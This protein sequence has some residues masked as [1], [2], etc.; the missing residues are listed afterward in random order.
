VRPTPRQRDALAVVAEGRFYPDIVR[1]EDG[2]H[3][4]WRTFGSDDNPWVDEFVRRAAAT[5]LAADAEHQRHETLHDAWMAALRSGTGLVVWDDGE[6]AEFAADLAE[7]HGGGEEDTAVRRAIV[8][9]FAPSKEGFS[10][11]CATPKGRKALKALGQAAYVFGPLRGLK[12]DGQML[13][14]R[15]E[16]AD[17]EAFLRQGAYELA[18]AGYTVED[19][20]VSAKVCASAEICDGEQADA[21]DGEQTC[22]AKLRIHVAGEEVSAA[23]IRFLLDQGSSLVWFRNRWIEVDRGILKEALRALEKSGGAKLSRMEAVAFASGIGR[24]GRLEMEEVALHGW[25][26]GLVNR[27]KDAGRGSL[28][29]E[30][31]P[32]DGLVS[33]ELRDYQKRGVAWMRFLV[34]NGFGALLADE[35]GLGKTIQTIAWV[36]ASR[37]D[38]PV[39]VVAPLTLLAN[40]RHE[41]ERFSPGLK[42]YVHQGDRRDL[43]IG[44]RR[45]ARAADVVVTSY[46]LLVRDHRDIAE[47]AW[48][49]LVLDEAQAIKNPDTQA[50]RSV[51]ALGARR[52]I[53]LTG[54]PVENSAADIWSIEEFLNPGL[55]GD[56][57]TFAERFLKP[58]AVEP[59]GAAAK[60]LR[61]ALEPF[62]LRRLKSDGGVAD[63]LGPKREIRE[64]CTLSDRERADYETALADYRASERRQG[65]VFALIT[66]LKLACDG[67]DAD[68]GKFMRLVEILEGVFAAGESALVFSQYAKVGAALKSAL[69]ARFSRRVRF[70]HG[71]L[72][73]KE[74]ERE[75]A[76][77]SRSREPSVMVLSLR[78]GGFGLNLVKAT[79]VI[80]YDRWWNPAVENQAT[81]RAHRIGQTGTVFVHLMMAEGTLE[82][83]V[84]GL[85]R[86]KS[87]LAGALVADGESFLARMS[88]SELEGVVRL[89]A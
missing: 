88:A 31:V 4:R 63:E 34:E 39:L 65:D 41:L 52:R 36:V 68:S 23:E 78:A 42:V 21:R 8:F 89:E 6:C 32:A 60:R 5:P 57:K 24:I 15:L 86:S 75:V 20:D 46:S 35:M 1:E 2:W 26:R 48:S 28:L 59:D 53:A 54:T 81:D 7:W 43:G 40:W 62:V 25:L 70:L 19:A 12:A 29:S 33:G 49:A 51:R 18:E 82:E 38:G 27:L 79:H 87:A 16:R 30:L 66:R 10:I 73:A 45:R 47:I 85:L 3:A 67:T 76:A 84:D 22:R 14:V 13:R 72:S 55:L 50:A 69:E 77:F 17:A 83:R 61:H 71:G 44:F 74:R 80:H 58:I 37:L 9:R 56:R 64:Y 11:E